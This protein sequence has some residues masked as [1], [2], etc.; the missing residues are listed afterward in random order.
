MSKSQRAPQ[1]FFQSASVKLLC[2]GVMSALCLSTAVAGGHAGAGKPHMTTP[3]TVAAS[4]T[5]TAPVAVEGA[6]VRATVKGQTG[7]GG[8]MTLRADRDLTLVGFRSAAAPHAELHEMKMDGDVMRMRAIE[9]LPLPAGQAVTLRPG[10]HHLMLMGLTQPL[11][12]GQTITLELLL[13]DAQGASVVQSVAVPVRASAPA[14]AAREPA[15]GH[16][17]HH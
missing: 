9:R 4:A 13:Q 6:W 16:H 3:P 12:A 15:G 2:S 17:H 1:G 14:G 11:S 7:T 8:F 10:G 5:A